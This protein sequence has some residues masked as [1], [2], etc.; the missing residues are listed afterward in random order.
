MKIIQCR[1]INVM[2]MTPKEWK[3]R[4]ELLQSTHAAVMGDHVITSVVKSIDFER[5]VA[6]TQNSI[7]V[8]EPLGS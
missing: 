1:L 3:L 6:I 2:Q 4:V 5:G 8:W 7:Y